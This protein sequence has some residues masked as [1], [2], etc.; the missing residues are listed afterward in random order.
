MSSPTAVV[1]PYTGL[2]RLQGPTIAGTTHKHS[3]RAYRSATG[4]ISA[5]NTGRTYK[6]GIWRYA[7]GIFAAIG[8]VSWYATAR[9][10]KRLLIMLAAGGFLPH[11]DDE[12]QEWGWLMDASEDAKGQPMYI[13]LDV[14]EQAID[15]LNAETLEQAEEMEANQWRWMVDAWAIRNA[16]AIAQHEPDVEMALIQWI[17]QQPLPEKG[18]QQ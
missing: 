10:R 13:P 6:M 11:T 17:A 7:T 3:R 5:H 4:L 16:M 8:A 18:D 12:G 9:E 2:Q 14:A 15:I 1:S